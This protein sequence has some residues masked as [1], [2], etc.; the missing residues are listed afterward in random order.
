MSFLTGAIMSTNSVGAVCIHITV[1][2]ANTAFIDI[3]DNKR[4]TRE[5]VLKFNI[6]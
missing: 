1:M 3:Y 6:Q 2:A 4:Y 5:T